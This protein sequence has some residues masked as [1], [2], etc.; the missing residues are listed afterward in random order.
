MANGWQRSVKNRPR[1]GVGYGKPVRVVAYLACSEDLTARYTQSDFPK[2][3]QIHFSPDD[4]AIFVISM[5]GI[6]WWNLRTSKNSPVFHCCL[7]K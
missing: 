5:M 3:L 1:V 2:T 6:T 7:K 4:K